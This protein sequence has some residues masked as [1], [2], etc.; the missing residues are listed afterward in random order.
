[1]VPSRMLL[2]AA[3]NTYPDP[4]P[5]RLIRYQCQQDLAESHQTTRQV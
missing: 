1:M 4:N 5:G 3:V 2:D